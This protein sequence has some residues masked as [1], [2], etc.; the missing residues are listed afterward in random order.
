[1]AIFT[2]SAI[3]AAMF[4]HEDAKMMQS[5]PQ[6]SD[7]QIRNCHTGINEL[8]EYQIKVTCDL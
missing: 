4:D 7:G 5:R 8:L 3:A 6:V 1:M 2:S